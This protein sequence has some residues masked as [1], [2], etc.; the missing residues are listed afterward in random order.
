ML[1]FS[2]LACDAGGKDEGRLTIF[3]NNNQLVSKLIKKILCLLKRMVDGKSISVQDE[4]RELSNS[5]IGRSVDTYF[6][7]RL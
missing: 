7:S 1:F 2:H 4:R 6:L 5:P 3:R